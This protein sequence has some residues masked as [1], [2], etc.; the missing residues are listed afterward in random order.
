VAVLAALVVFL[1]SAAARL[2]R[3]RGGA[4]AG[5]TPGGA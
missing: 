1:V 5:D 4:G 3:D 2:L